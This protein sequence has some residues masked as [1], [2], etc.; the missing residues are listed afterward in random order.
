MGVFQYDNPLIRFM[1]KLANLMVISFFW[2]LM[3]IPVVTIVPS[4]TAM[5]LTVA[6]I[7]NGSGEGVVRAFFT[8]FKGSV[9]KGIALSLILVV[10]GLL[11]YTALDF[12]AQMWKQSL[13]GIAYLSF[14][15]M[16][17]LILVPWVIYIP[18]TCARF[19]GRL[20]VILRLALYFTWKNPLRTILYIII[21]AVIFLLIDFYPILLLL[22]PAVYMDLIHSGIEK[23][24][25]AYLKDSGID[26]GK[27]GS[28]EAAAETSEDQSSN[29]LFDQMY[30]ED[31]QDDSRE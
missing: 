22:L 23:M 12:G 16:L 8:E 10:C 3:C 7:V 31:D 4:T 2:A 21:F 5:Y 29:L 13:W 17:T 19:S 28:G 24:I 1:I 20:G 6:D 26:V 25:S 15:I 9:K 27:D 30:G 14:G 11:L 18:P